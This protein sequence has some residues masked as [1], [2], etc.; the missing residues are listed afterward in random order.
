MRPL[1]D[2]RAGSARLLLS[3]SF[4]L[5]VFFSLRPHTL[6][7]APTDGRGVT[8]VEQSTAVAAAEQAAAPEIGA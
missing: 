5:P 2:S 6:S 3:I 4:S 7:G 1:C 8:A